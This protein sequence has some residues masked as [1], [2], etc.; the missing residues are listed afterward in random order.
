VVLIG[1]GVDYFLFL[2]FRVRERLR[3][4]EPARVAAAEAGARIAPVIGLAALVL[5]VAFATLTFA[6][7]GQ[8][9]LL[10]PSIAVSVGVMLLAGVTLMPAVAALA[11]PR[12]FW[13]SRRWRAPEADGWA[14]RLGRRVV[15]APGRTALAAAGLLAVLAA[16]APAAELD[17]DLG[18]GGPATA[19]TRTADRIASALSSG[20]ADPQPVFVRAPAALDDAELDALRAGLAAAPGVAEASAAVLADGRRAA[21]IDLVLDDEPTSA[22]ATATIRGPVRAALDERTPPG[23]TAA[24]AGDAAVLADVSDAVTRDMRLVLPLAA[25]L[26]A[27]VLVAALRSVRI[28]LV[29]L[30]VVALEFAATL[31]ATVAVVQLLGGAPGVAFTLPLVIFLFVVAVGT[32]YNVL[33][34]ARIREELRRNPVGRGGGRRGPACGSGDHGGRAR[35][36]RV[37]R[38]ARPGCRPRDQ[39]DGLRPRRRDPHRRAGGLERP[40]PVARGARHAPS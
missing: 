22:A 12:L 11:G 27:A 20:T 29:L 31:G 28:A 5:A 26:I 39:G 7:F 32:D 10:G 14:Q 4:G 16:F 30:A 18:S 21:R 37:V 17:Y 40:R 8:F 35:P 23:A 3:A 1:I 9:R 25:L 19:A 15:R 38:D 2:L 6:S 24:A 13:P 33:I 34:A 36:R